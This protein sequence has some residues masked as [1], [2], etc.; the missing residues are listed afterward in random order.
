[1]FYSCRR[2]NSSQLTLPQLFL[3]ILQLGV[4]DPQTLGVGGWPPD[5]CQIPAYREEEV[6]DGL[7]AL[8]VEIQRGARGKFVVTN[9]YMPPTR[10][11][12]QDGFNPG[13]IRY[14]LPNSSLRATSIHIPPSG[15]TPSPEMG[16]EPSWRSGQWTMT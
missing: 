16:L 4:T 1:M 7:E 14:Q 3:G 9:L 11:G 6:A 5:L 2:P 8:A 15:M 10:E 13:A 12:S